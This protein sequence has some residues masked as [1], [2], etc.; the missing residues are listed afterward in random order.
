[1]TERLVDQWIV[2]TE[3][4]VSRCPQPSDAEI[5][6]SLERLRNS[7]TSTQEY[8][9]R[10]RQSGL[11]DAEIREMVAAQLYLTNNTDSR[12]RSG[13]QIDP[14]TIEDFYQKP[15]VPQPKPTGQAPPPRDTTPP[16]T[17]QPLPPP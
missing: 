8:E 2:R 12:F 4:N 15:P 7:F 3:A 11:N 5:E 17:P 13:V 10:R 16:S 6:R 1:M 14:T 9:A